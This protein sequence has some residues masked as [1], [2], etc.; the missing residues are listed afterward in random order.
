MPVPNQSV[1]YPPAVLR[2]D[3]SAI[4]TVREALDRTLDELGPHLLRMRNDAYI[5]EAWLGDPASESMRVAY[6]TRVMDAADG[7][8]QALWA[9]AQRLREARD[10]LAAIEAEYLRTEG[11]N[12]AL[13]GRRA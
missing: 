8:Y 5:R 10:Q 2:V 4:P 7:P 9:Y 3:P 6:N 11:A 13:W 1:E 12:S